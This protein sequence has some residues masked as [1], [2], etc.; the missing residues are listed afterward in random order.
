MA[1]AGAF[2]FGWGIRLCTCGL[3]HFYSVLALA[4]RE[5]VS[6]E[7]EALDALPAAQ[8]IEF[9]NLEDIPV[10]QSS[11]SDSTFVKMFAL[12]IGALVLFTVIIMA[13]ANMMSY[14]DK[15]MDELARAVLTKRVAP[16][17]S[18]RTSDTVDE[19]VVAAAPKSA[20]ELYAICGAC[21]DTGAA[22]APL[23][24]DAAAWEARLAATGGLEGMVKSAIVGKGGMPPRGGSAYSDEEMEAVVKFLV[25]Q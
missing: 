22:S 20:A 18:V 6:V 16:A 17:G 1:R 24:G 10:S 4:Q 8:S 2:H 13:M 5:S 11:S 12:V 14:S 9:L 15:P 23:K 3:G 7:V 25:G 21:H 19:P